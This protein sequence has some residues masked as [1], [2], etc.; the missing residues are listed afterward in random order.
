MADFDLAILQADL[1]QVDVILY[2]FD[3]FVDLHGIVDIFNFEA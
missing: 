3:E 1:K 2:G